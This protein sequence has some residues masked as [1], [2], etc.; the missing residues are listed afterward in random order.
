M[1]NNSNKQ[2]INM[3]RPNLSWLYIIIAMTIAFLYITSDE[4][5]MSK[6]ITYTEFKEMVKKGYA[7]KI[8]AYD[9]NSVEMYIKPENIVDVFKKDAPK[10]GKSP[11]VK[12]Q[13]GSMESLDKFL[14]EEQKNGNF[15][16]S[17][18]YEKENDYFGVI[19]WNLLP[20]IFFIGLWIFIMRRMGGAGNA[21]GAGNVFNVGKSKAQLFEKGANRVTFKDVAGQ[22]AAKQEVQ[23]IVEFL[24]QPQKYTEL[25]GKIPKGAL[26]VGPPGTGKTL[27]AKAV[28]GEA[29]VP[30]FSMSGSD[31][32]EMFVGVGAS[33]V[34][35]LFRQA[36][37]KAPCIIFIDEI[38][39]VG[40]AR[41][42]NPNMGGNDER[43]NTLNQLLTEMD[44]FGTNSGVI[45]LAATNRADILDK[46]L[47]RAGR[48]DRQIH[49][50][51][52]DLNERKEVFGVHIRPLKLDDTVD[53]D[54][55]ARQTPGFSGADIANV[56]N[57]AALIAARH[58]KTSVSKDD[59]MAAIDRIVGGLEKKTKVMTAAEKRSIALHE[60][61][62]ATISWFLEYANP[63][64]K[65]TIVPRGR[66]LGAA[67]YLP[68][69]R[70]ITTK[71][72]MLDEMC[73]TLGGRAAE[74]LFIKQISTGAMNDLERVTK[75]AYGMIAYAG[76]SDKLPNLCYYNNDEYSFNKPYSEHTAELIDSEVK[77]MI[78][79][80]YDRAK[81]ILTEHKEGH[82]RLAELLIEKEVIFAEDVEAIFGKRPWASRSEEI[83]A[84][85]ENNETKSIES[86][87]EETKELPSSTESDTQNGE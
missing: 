17:I 12:I 21:G 43:E 68:E 45:I 57:E 3:P 22:T 20:I 55:L 13:V 40:R 34:R 37:E 47:L 35:D 50:D 76:M 39:A 27:L 78:A 9:N 73:A 31:F 18:R 6:E 81:R 60:A 32:V 82:N 75:Q 59:F 19:F 77:Q 14:D 5:S 33:R 46:A 2:K 64:I 8:I 53:I 52:P 10:V 65:V 62:H 24:K 49:V 69:E 26:L 61:G 28:A 36:K 58:N 83:M 41:G 23:E 72:Q 67:W 7:D 15:T 38:D 51:L 74:E 54:L 48:F 56:C 63:L 84:E 1:N 4:G 85:N 70:Q 44:G 71:E 29:D 16:G 66:A 42:K 25:G 30:F 86:K 87:N 79:E 11:S 80:Q